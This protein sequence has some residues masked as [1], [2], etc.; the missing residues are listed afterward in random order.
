[1]KDAKKLYIQTFGCQM[2]VRDSERI[3]GI[4]QRLN[5]EPAGKPS[6]A[7]LI[8]I[9]TCSIR[10]KVEHKT[11]SALGRFKRLKARKPELVLGLGG[12]VAQQEGEALLER[13]PYLDL[14]IGT[15]QIHRLPELIRTVRER[16][17]RIA[18]TTLL[19][20]SP[21]RFRG[22]TLQIPNPSP[23]WTSGQDYQ[24]PGNGNRVKA[25]VT[26]MEGCDNYCSYCIVPYVR[27]REISRSSDDI[28][29]EITDLA[30]CGV[31]E[32]TLIGQNVNSYRG[33]GSGTSFPDLLERING[34]TGL[35][36]IRFTTTHPRDLS[37]ELIGSFGRR[38]KLCE[39]I[40]LPLQSGSD[41]VLRQMNR[42]Y[43]REDYLHKVEQLRRASSGIAIS[44]DILVG[45]PGEREED[46]NDTLD[47]LKRV[48]FDAI[49][50]F[51]Y[52]H[53]P[54]AS[55]SRLSED[56]PEEEK[57][58]RLGLIQ[59]VQRQITLEKN[60]ELIGNKE[61]VLV[62]GPSRRDPEWLTGRT[63]SN[64]VVNF[65][66]DK[67]LIGQLVPVEITKAYQNS[68]KAEIL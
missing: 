25:L 24:I 68:L 38:E 63:R 5:Y 61:E 27:G 30:Q 54:P 55:A 65:P 62:E 58:R 60:R 53:R 3:V 42:G 66:G 43:S 18:A 22:H 11:Y 1:M 8:L 45:F 23:R 2:N 48:R 20:G 12:C 44:T 29:R 13:F 21:E 15:H 47:L 46:F 34:I 57:G 26:V 9:N 14:V 56:V 35:F 16:K 32:V 41:S 37:E 10:Q 59:D 4:M 31:R 39:H 7:D 33:N 28:L 64:R 6:R 52:S 19:N 36:R 40:H 17:E 67:D 51:K 49:F 50:S